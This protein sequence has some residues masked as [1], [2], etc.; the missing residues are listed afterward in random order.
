MYISYTGGGIFVYHSKDV[1]NKAVANN[2]VIILKPY[3]CPF[4]RVDFY[5]YSNS[6]DANN[7]YII[8]PNNRRFYSRSRVYNMKVSRIINPSG[9]RLRNYATNTPSY[10]GIYT[11]QLPDSNGNIL[12]INIG[13]YDDDPRMFI[14]HILGKMYKL[15]TISIFSLA[16]L[17]YLEAPCTYDF[18]FTDLSNAGQE[19]TPFGKIEIKTRYSPPTNVTWKRDGVTVYVHPHVGGAGYEMTQVLTSRRNSEYSSFLLIRNAAHLTG[20]HTYTF[21]VSNSEGTIIT[22]LQ[23]QVKGIPFIG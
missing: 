14:L 8:F 4:C 18:E 5:C 2:S 10:E 6:S 22:E 16:I 3:S 7:T 15:F 12:N 20:N 23:T 11:C 21:I 1:N 17:F 19:S 13:Y 9:I